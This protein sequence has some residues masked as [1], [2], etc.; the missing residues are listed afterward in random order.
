MVE[1]TTNIFIPKKTWEEEGTVLI[2]LKDFQGSRVGHL[3]KSRAENKEQRA[4]VRRRQ[5]SM[6]YK[7]ILI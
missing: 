5:L 3:I 1:G 4:D 7:V 2:Y 6:K